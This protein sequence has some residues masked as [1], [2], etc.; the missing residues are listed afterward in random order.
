MGWTGFAACSNLDGS[1]S[2]KG[3][4]EASAR[5]ELIYTA[6]RK[7]HMN[8]TTFTFKLLSAPMSG[9]KTI[10]VWRI[11]PAA[12]SSFIDGSTGYPGCSTASSSAGR[13]T[14]RAAR[15]HDTGP[16]FLRLLRVCRGGLKLSGW[17]HCG[18]FCSSQN[19]RESDSAPQALRNVANKRRF[20]IS[21]SKCQ[22]FTSSSAV[23]FCKHFITKPLTATLGSA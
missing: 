23:L 9:R 16:F 21:E 2:P 14:K 5:E 22:H 19:K 8:M 13:G 17:H 3:P 12:S 1:G 6:Q 15:A 18:A 4:L 7:A 11:S 20:A 10:S